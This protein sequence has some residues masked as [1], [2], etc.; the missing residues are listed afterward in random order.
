MQSAPQD[1][2]TSQ[3]LAY[4][5]DIENRQNSNDNPASQ[6]ELQS[7]PVLML[8]NEAYARGIK[9]LPVD[10]EKSSDF[11]Y[12]PENGKIRLPYMSLKGVG[13]A[14]AIQIEKACEQ[15]ADFLSVEDFQKASGVSTAVIDTLYDV[16]ALG[17]MPKTNQ[18][19]FFNLMG[20]L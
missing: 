3:L 16:G 12:L 7:L 13:E 8:V 17:N 5:A 19:S 1:E 4:I 18:V 11:E 2:N 10:L 20:E 15:T 9:F 14:A 6:K